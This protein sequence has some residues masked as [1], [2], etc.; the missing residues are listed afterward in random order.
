MLTVLQLI[1]V[2]LSLLV[3]GAHFLRAGN[4]LMVG[5]CLALLCLLFVRKPLAARLLQA[6]LLLGA[7]EWIRTL[8]ALA[9][10]RMDAGQPYLRMAVIL[11]IVAAVTGLSALLFQTRRLGRVYGTRPGA[12]D[13]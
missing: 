7:L 13:R 11:G 8:A 5:T 3:L 9:G 10:G 12:A 6:A 1:P 4:T 2:V